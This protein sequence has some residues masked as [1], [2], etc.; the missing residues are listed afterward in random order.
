VHS[1]SKERR[2]TITADGNE[3]QVVISAETL[4]RRRH[5]TIRGV[6]EIKGM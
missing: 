1:L 6:G 4:Q 2:S 3:M 5:E